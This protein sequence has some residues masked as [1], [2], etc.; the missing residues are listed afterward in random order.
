MSTGQENTDADREV[1]RRFSQAT[2]KHDPAGVD[3]NLL[4]AYLEGRTGPA[5]SE[6]VESAMAAGPT[7]LA[8]V[9]QL[10]ELLAAP[11]VLAPASVKSGARGLLGAPEP[12]AAA[13]P[14]ARARVLRPLWRRVAEMAA[15]AAAVLVVSGFGYW[16]GAS[17]S[18]MSVVASS[19]GT[20]DLVSGLGS[21]MAMS[22]L[23]S[24][25]AAPGEEGGRP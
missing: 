17:T 8:E 10:R 5:E 7:R 2:S 9:R 22:S 23:W 13:V 12:Q 6:A 1:W 25:A 19:V 11:P 21:G 14:A 16:L 18:S 15:A 20:R 4:A 3:P 24:D